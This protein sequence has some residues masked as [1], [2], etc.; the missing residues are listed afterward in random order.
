MWNDSSQQISAFSRGAPQVLY[1]PYADCGRSAGG[2][3][4][5]SST[6]A[7]DPGDDDRPDAQRAL[8]QDALTRG[9]RAHAVPRQSDLARRTTR[10][11]FGGSSRSGN[12]EARQQFLEGYVAD[13]G[14]GLTVPDP[15]LRV[16]T[17]A[18]GVSEPDWASCAPSSPARPPSQERSRSAAGSSTRRLGADRLARGMIYEVFRRGARDALQA[19]FESRL[20]IRPS[21]RSGRASSTAGAASPRRLARPAYRGS[22]RSST[23]R[24]VRSQVAAS[25]ATRSG[26]VEGGA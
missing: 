22:T 4:P 17:T 6:A 9:G 19:G 7:R 23:G 13:P 2:V 14:V 8:V 26:T 1:A 15:K 11:G 25:T 5:T 24:R 12:E 21:P 20:R 16:A 18:L 10:C 3:V